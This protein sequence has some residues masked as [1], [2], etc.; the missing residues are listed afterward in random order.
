MPACLPA[1]PPGGH[2]KPQQTR[3]PPQ[4]ATPPA[5]HQRPCSH[6]LTIL[7]G[8]FAVPFI[9]PFSLP[10]GL[11]PEYV[12]FTPQGMKVGAA[13][14]M[15]RPEALEAMWYM[16]RLTHDWK[17]RAW[18]WEIFQAFETHSKVRGNPIKGVMCAWGCLGLHAGVWTARLVV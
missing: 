15:L 9:H 12:T 4:T 17:Y 11:S 13:Y 18:A 1:W 16:W 6:L 2:A 7:S 8:T 14:N 3:S 5:S 10:A